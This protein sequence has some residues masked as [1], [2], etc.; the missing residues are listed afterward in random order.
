M[1]FFKARQELAALG[2]YTDEELSRFSVARK[3][4]LAQQCLVFAG[5]RPEAARALVERL[6]GEYLAWYDYILGRRKSI[7]KG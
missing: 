4:Q 5:S 2:E 6:G 1:R 7:S 3:Y